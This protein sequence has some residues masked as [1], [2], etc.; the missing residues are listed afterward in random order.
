M[1]TT[2]IRP[3]SVMMYCMAKLQKNYYDEMKNIMSYFSASRLV[4]ELMAR[5]AGYTGY[6]CKFDRGLPICP[7]TRAFCDVYILC[8]YKV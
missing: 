6:I 5:A 1:S 2:I 4:Y 8:E 3:N 7:C